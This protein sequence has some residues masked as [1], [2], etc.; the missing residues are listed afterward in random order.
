MAH[1]RGEG[2]GCSLGL[3]ICMY[4][5]FQNKHSVKYV[6]RISLDKCGQL[7]LEA[8]LDKISCWLVNMSSLGSAQSL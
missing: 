3:H 7:G 1:R 8:L 4:G 5:S 2:T 6:N